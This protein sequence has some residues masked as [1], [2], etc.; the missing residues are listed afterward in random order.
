MS[1][2]HK[3]HLDIYDRVVATNPNFERKGKTMHFTS[4]NGYMFSQL[5]KAGELGVRLGKEGCK[6]FKTEHADADDF[7]SY[8]TKMRDYVRIPDRLLENEELL[9]QL[10]QQAFEHVMSLEP[11]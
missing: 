9:G 11:K 6:A 3:K 5:N 2:K 7:K 4:A 8:G 1:A 10:L